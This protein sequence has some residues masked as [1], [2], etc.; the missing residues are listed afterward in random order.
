MYGLRIVTYLS[1]S[2][3]KIWSISLDLLLLRPIIWGKTI[4]LESFLAIS[5]DS[6]VTGSV[7]SASRNIRG[8]TNPCAYQE[9]LGRRLNPVHLN[10]K[11]AQIAET[12]HS[13]YRLR[14]GCSYS[15]NK[16]H[17]V[18]IYSYVIFLCS[19]LTII[20]MGLINETYVYMTNGALFQQCIFTPL[21]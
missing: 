1:F 13:V 15:M 10:V 2:A 11:H 21:S 3:A 14:L 17:W 20:Y 6:H 18:L 4:I 8:I 19:E 12:E 9:H 5:F 7:W 16:S